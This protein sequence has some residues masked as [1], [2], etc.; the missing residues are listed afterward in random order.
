M[1]EEATRW[2]QIGFKKLDFPAARFGPNGLTWESPVTTIET[3]KRVGI[4][5]FK[6]KLSAFLRLVEAGES[7]IVTDRGREI[8]EVR[9]RGQ[10]AQSSGAYD[11]MVARGAIRPPLA[12]DDLEWLAEP[13]PR[14]PAGT[15]QALIDAQRGE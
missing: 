6:S 3:M 10:Q 1:H 5:E 14:L 4:K 7:L 9:R 8:A 15:A 11:D 12:P 2:V 13:G